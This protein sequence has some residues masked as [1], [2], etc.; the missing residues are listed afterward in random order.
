[1][2]RRWLRI[3]S[4][5]AALV[6]IGSVLYLY[7]RGAGSDSSVY[8][9]SRQELS[10]SKPTFLPEAASTYLEQEA[11]I[12][13][14]LNTTG[15]LNLNTAKNAMVNVENITSEYVIGSIGPQVYSSSDDYPHCFVHKDGWIVVYYLKP[16]AQNKAWL[17][18]IIDWSD[19]NPVSDP[20]TNNLLY[21]GLYYMANILGKGGELANAKY[22]HFQ[23]PTATKLL[24]AIKE[25][26]AGQ[27]KTFNAK[28]P[29]SCTI[30]ERSWSCWR[31]PEQGG[32]SYTFM[33]D[34]NTII[35][36]VG[37]R[38]YGGP[39]ITAAIL[40]TDD[41]FHVISISASTYTSYPAYVCLILL[42]SC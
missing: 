38:K 34:G 37:G 36:S 14:Y 26:P 1:M 12:T 11:G 23:H 31:Y 24:F 30:Y 41:L 8:A 17:G 29:S 42:Y 33:I 18:K 6:L 5:L 4:I 13:Y 2:E 16:T 7:S 28:I 35:S 22:Y 39:E 27:T 21:D 19:T 3:V 9:E 15:P 10:L 20:I 25:T 32:G 40:P